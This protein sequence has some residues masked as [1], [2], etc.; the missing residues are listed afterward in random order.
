LDEGGEF[1][2]SSTL[3]A[4]DFLGVGCADDNVGDGG[5]NS[6]FY[7][8]VSFLGQFTLEELVQLGVEDTI[9]DKLSP[10]R[11]VE[12]KCMLVSAN[13][14]FGVSVRGF[15]HSGTWYTGGHIDGIMI[16]AIEPGEEGSISLVGVVVVGYGPLSWIKINLDFV[17]AGLSLALFR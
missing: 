17:C 1:T 13:C 15:L 8:R 6:D 2:N 7:A 9:C 16:C 12:L 4:E 11:A 14:H 5:S 10:L 3:L